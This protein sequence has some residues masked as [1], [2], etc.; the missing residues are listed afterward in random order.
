MNPHPA[1]RFSVFGKPIAWQRAGRNGSTYFSQPESAGYRQHV[2]LVASAAMGRAGPH[3]TP[4][5]LTIRVFLTVPK[6]F[7]AW[8]REAAL[9]GAIRPSGKPDADNFAKA[10]MDACNGIVW[11]DDAQ[12]VDLTVSKHYAADPRVEVTAEALPCLRADVSRR[13]A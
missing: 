10:I 7:T 3:G 8:K 4:I 2:A 13:A 12:V 6:S 9:S 5:A 11:S 1:T